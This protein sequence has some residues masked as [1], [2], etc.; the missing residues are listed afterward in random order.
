MC[1]LGVGWGRGGLNTADSRV[2]VLND[3]ADRLDGSGVRV[4]AVRVR[5]MCGVCV[6]VCACVRA[7]VHACV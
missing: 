7:R 1:M 5:V 3:I 2:V 6:C 4:G